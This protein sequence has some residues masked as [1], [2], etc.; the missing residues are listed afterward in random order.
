M[1]KNQIKKVLY[2][3]KPIAKLIEVY[4]DV[5]NVVWHEYKAIAL[6]TTIKFLIPDFDLP[7]TL[8]NQEPAQLLIRWLV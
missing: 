8:T 1:D 3:E 2:K 4:K 5:N 7:E 6:G